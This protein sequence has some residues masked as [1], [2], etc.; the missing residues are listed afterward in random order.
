MNKDNRISN[1]PEV[2]K[3]LADSSLDPFPERAIISN[4]GNADS[5]ALFLL[6]RSGSHNEKITYKNCDIIIY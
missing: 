6:T 5:E 2:K 1:L 3:L 4:T